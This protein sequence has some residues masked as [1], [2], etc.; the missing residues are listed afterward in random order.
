MLVGFVG[1]GAVAWISLQPEAVPEPQVAAAPTPPPPAPPQ[2]VLVLV[3]SRTLRA[4]SLLR[5]EDLM[6]VSMLATNVPSD[7]RLETRENR[8][9][10]QGALLRR[11]LR[12]GDIILDQDV[13]L[14]G[15]RGYLAASLSPN[16]RAMPI[17]VD[18]VSGA[19]GLIWPGDRVDVMLTQQLPREEAALL[20][21]RTSGEVVAQDA[22]VIAVDQNLVQGAIG[23]AAEGFRAAR[24][25]TLEVSVP[26]AE[27]LS[28]A[29]R[30]GLLSLILRPAQDASEDVAQS[31]S[32]VV[33]GGDASSALRQTQTIPGPASVLH[34]F[35][36]VRPRE[37]TR[38]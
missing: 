31:E 13:V 23:D 18:Q 14:P 2:R 10:I 38:F 1:I 9:G 33:W 8:S 3:A 4:G 35:M 7:A 6:G 27:R 37:E 25:V 5:P 22:R 20:A 12:E 30:L 36:G 28:V 15:D 21:R 32:S 29:R 19:A 24:V 11:S 17:A 16:M 34:I 26:Q